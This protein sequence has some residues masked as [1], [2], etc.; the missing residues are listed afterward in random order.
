[1]LN[2]APPIPSNPYVGK[3]SKPIKRINAPEIVAGKNEW[4][5]IGSNI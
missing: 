2:L 4:T 1:M 3:T 5:M